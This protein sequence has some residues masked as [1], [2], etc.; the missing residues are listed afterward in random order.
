M[1]QQHSAQTRI[2][3]PAAVSDAVDMMGLA[4]RINGHLANSG[5]ID[6]PTQVSRPSAPV[7]GRARVGVIVDVPPSTPI[8]P[9]GLGSFMAE[10]EPGDILVLA[11]HAA[12]VAS[13]CGGLAAKFAQSK[14]CVALI[15]EGW[16]RDIDEIDALGFPVWARGTTPRT[17]KGRIRFERTDDPIRVGGVLVREGDTVVADVSGICVVGQDVADKVLRTARET[18]ELELTF[19]TKLDLGASFD[20]AQEETG[21][22]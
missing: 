20:T 14:G 16:V 12:A 2:P 21:V 7:L 8:E 17:G 3:G 19:A 5:V 22:S 10:L 18:S 15:T 1:T 13:C 9:P 6:G 11:W 4:G